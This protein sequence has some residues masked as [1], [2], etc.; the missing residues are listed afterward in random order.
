MDPFATDGAGRTFR[1]SW[2]G[3]VAGAAVL[4]CSHA[5]ALGLLQRWLG[6]CTARL[7]A[8]CGVAAT[9]C[10][11]LAT[12]TGSLQT[13][14]GRVYQW[15]LASALAGAFWLAFML[16][17]ST[18]ML[19][20]T[21][22]AACAATSVAVAGAISAG[23]AG[24]GAWLLLP[25]T[26]GAQWAAVQ[27]AARRGWRGTL[28]EW[29][30]KRQKGWVTAAS[31]ASFRFTAA[32]LSAGYVPEAVTAGHDVVFDVATEWRG[33]VR[34]AH[35]S[36]SVGGALSSGAVGERRAVNISQDV[37]PP[38]GDGLRVMRVSGLTLGGLR[39]RSD[40]RAGLGMEEPH[41]KPLSRA[42]PVL[43]VAASS[44]VLLLAA[45]KWGLCLPIADGRSVQLELAPGGV[46]ATVRCTAGAGAP[47]TPAPPGL[48]GAAARRQDPAAGAGAV[49]AVKQGAGGGGAAA[50]AGS[51]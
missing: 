16:G 9:G 35:G 34:G 27:A 33:P 42:R 48:R 6:S 45:W 38:A 50:A 51:R 10:A 47:P 46:T 15:A 8:A 5:C 32:G 25:V 4:S 2:G 14:G 19:H 39:P 49:A 36:S 40:S 24:S 28:A 31:G 43:A 44:G 13:D 11:V 37:P 23:G 41:A 20:A 26:C 7:A 21:F 17:Q 12:A 30:P 1:L 29:D 18:G 22:A 3:L